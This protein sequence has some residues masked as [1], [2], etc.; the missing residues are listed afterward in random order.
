MTR[1]ELQAILTPEM[2]GQCLRKLGETKYW[3]LLATGRGEAVG[4]WVWDAAADTVRDRDGTSMCLLWVK[5]GGCPIGRLLHAIRCAEELDVTLQLLCSTAE[6]LPG[7]QT[8]DLGGGASLTVGRYDESYPVM[9]LAR[10]GRK[11]PP[12]QA[13]ED[14]GTRREGDAGRPG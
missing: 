2:F 14:A 12:E 4:F 8:I 1:E 9:H 3:M 7:K 11:W 10:H 13:I 6:A 5:P